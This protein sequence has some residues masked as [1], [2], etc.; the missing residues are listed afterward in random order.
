MQNMIIMRN[1]EIRFMVS[2]PPKI[3]YKKLWNFINQKLKY[4]KCRAYKYL[5]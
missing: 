2:Q 4:R 5:N 1:M 3:V